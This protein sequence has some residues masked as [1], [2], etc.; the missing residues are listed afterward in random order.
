[1]LAQ[2]ESKYSKNFNLVRV[3]IEAKSSIPY[4]EYID[5]K[6]SGGIP[7]F[8]VLTKSGLKVG[9]WVGA[10]TGPSAHKHMAQEARSILKKSR[11]R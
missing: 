4:R 1:M 7:S 9:G 10:F 5:V 3:D 6:P 8:A 2:F 11:S